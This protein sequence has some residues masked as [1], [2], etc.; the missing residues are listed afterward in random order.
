MNKSEKFVAFLESLKNGKN[1]LLIE[2]VKQ[3]F[4]LME[5]EA[6]Q[7]EYANIVFVQGDEAEEPL[8]I[9]DEQGSDEAA[10]YLSQWDNGEYDDVSDEAPWG[11][12]DS[13]EVVTVPDAGKYILTYN[14]GLGYIALVKKVRKD[15]DRY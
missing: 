11:E 14:T 7:Y 4:S 13:V 5:A 12:S 8:K 2:S 1:D 15:T 6:P 9:L 10:K 3:G